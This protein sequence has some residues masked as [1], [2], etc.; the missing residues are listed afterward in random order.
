MHS[1]AAIVLQTVVGLHQQNAKR[2]V[3][4]VQILRKE[5]TQRILLKIISRVWQQ[6]A[7]M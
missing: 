6:A 3:V 2:A 5:D 1:A 4:P 7:M